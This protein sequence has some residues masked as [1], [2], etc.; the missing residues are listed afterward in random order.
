METSGQNPYNVIIIQMY[1][2]IVYDSGHDDGA[3]DTHLLVLFT[4]ISPSYGGHFFNAIVSTHDA[5][6]V[7]FGLQELL[8][9]KV[10]L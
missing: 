8:H 2:K 1:S 7:L 9:C 10:A 4:S 5:L 3:I 6:R